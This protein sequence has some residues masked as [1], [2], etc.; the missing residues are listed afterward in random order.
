[1]PRT[2][3]RPFVLVYPVIDNDTPH[4]VLCRETYGEESEAKER[5]ADLARQYHGEVWLFREEPTPAEIETTPRVT[6]GVAHKPL[7]EDR[8][9]RTRRTKAQM[10]AARAAGEVKPKKAANGAVTA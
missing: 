1:M 5:Y 3:N 10:E 8:P 6:F 2:S 7:A 9:K 4:P